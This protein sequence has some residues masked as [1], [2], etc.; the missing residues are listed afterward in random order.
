MDSFSIGLSG[1]E[2]AKNA[3]DIIGNNVANAATPGYHRQRVDISPEYL[4]NMGGYIQGGGV[5]FEGISQEIDVFLEMELLRQRSVLGQVSKELSALQTI[6]TAFGEL[7]GSSGLNATINEFFF[8]LRELSAHP[9]EVIYQHQVLASAETLAAQFRVLGNTLADLQSKMALEAENTIQEANALFAQIAELNGKIQEVEITGGQAHNLLDQRDQLV[10]D[11]SE[12]VGVTTNKVDNGVVNL[13]V[14]GIPVVTGTDYI[15]LEVALV[16]EDTLGISIEGAENYSSDVQGGKL[17]ALF[18]LHNEKI[19]QISDDLDSLVSEIIQQ[20][21]Q[22]HVQGVGSYGS[23]IDL[24]GW[25]VS[26]EDL[27]DFDPP[28]SDGAFYIRVIDTTTGQI[29]RNRIDVDVSTDT[30]TTIAAAISTVTGLSAS[31][32]SSQLRIQADSGY[33]FDFIPALLEGPTNSNL[34]AGSPPAVTVS[35]IY[36]GSV[37]QTYTFTVSGTGSVGNGTMQI[38]ARNGAGELVSTLNVGAGYV[39][40]DKLT[41]ENGIE[42]SLSTGDLNDLDTFEI[43]TFANTDTSGFLAAAALNT[44]FSGNNASNITVSEDISNSPDRIATSL[45]PD[46]TDNGNV[47]RLVD[48]QETSAGALNSLTFND[49]YRK[50]V[51]DIG[52]EITLAQM[53][54]DNGRILMKEYLNQRDQISGVD[55]NDEAARMLIFEQMFEAMAKYLEQVQKAIY[56]IM[57]II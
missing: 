45:G 42:I 55:I 6:E 47:D 39:A 33:E 14:A 8:S 44:F 50:L 43:D 23:F 46:M 34:T 54:D 22:I 53:R 28:I 11:L 38:E 21:N 27:A 57:E 18:S 30:L 37:N 36:T 26:D 16:S 19:T 56:T 13:V 24:N 25:S 31:V 10:S 51:T 1:L 20:V 41:I 9:V 49:F 32:A 2:V 29:T 40:G 12:L 7:S 5:N 48:L 3:L 35:G 17:G 52:Q 15:T 4:V